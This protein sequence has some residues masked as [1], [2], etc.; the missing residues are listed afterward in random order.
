MSSASSPSEPRFLFVVGLMR[1]GTSVLYRLLNSHPGIALMYETN[2]LAEGPLLR[3]AGGPGAW[4][5][6]L[7]FWN[8]V[9]SRHGIEREAAPALPSR[10][11]GPREAF[12]A[13]AQAYAQPKPGAYIGCKSVHYCDHL[14]AIARAFPNARFIV[15]WRPLGEI[16][17]SLLRSGRT[18]PYLAPVRRRRQVIQNFGQL[19]AG[20]VALR[21]LGAPVQELL[22]RDLVTDPAGV[23]RGLCNFLELAWTPAMLALDPASVASIPR[24]DHHFHARNTAAGV[25][26]ARDLDVPAALATTVRAYEAF[27][28][29][30]FAG[31]PVLNVPRSALPPGPDPRF[32]VFRRVTDALLYR[33]HRTLIYV[34]LLVYRFAPTFVLRW[35]RSRFGRNRSQTGTV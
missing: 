2:I 30:K 15:L 5:Q 27:W 7:E 23:S 11:G 31:Q 19:A 4:S 33:Q 32:F 18:N 10:V 28:A 17:D 8:G 22:Y 25:L 29:K 34:K 24:E 21:R 35:Y 16:V 20:V 9:L 26:P 13:M 14:P 12:A 1:S 3:P 6:R